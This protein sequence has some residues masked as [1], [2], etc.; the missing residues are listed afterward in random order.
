M[1]N[2]KLMLKDGKGNWATVTIPGAPGN[3]VIFGID[4]VLL[5]KLA[6]SLCFRFKLF[7]RHPFNKKLR[8][9]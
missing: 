1:K 5:P 3:G 6:V 4:G 9:I 2:C 8:T 7:L